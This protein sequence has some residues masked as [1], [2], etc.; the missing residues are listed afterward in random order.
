MRQ[1]VSRPSSRKRSVRRAVEQAVAA[2]RDE[3]L[4]HDV[5]LEPQV[6][7][8]ARDVGRADLDDALGSRAAVAR[9]LAAEL[10]RVGVGRVHG[11]AQA[12]RY[13]R[14]TGG[15][16]AER[17]RVVSPVD[18]RMVAERALADDAEIARCSSAPARRRRAGRRSRCARAR[19]VSA[20]VDAAEARAAEIAE[21]LTLADGAPDRAQPGRG[22][23]AR[24]ARARDDGARR[25]GAG[26]PRARRRS[27]ISP[28]SCAAS[29]SASCW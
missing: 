12:G 14:A 15:G 4:S 22:A 25:G 5:F 18:G 27:P 26:R 10:E 19:R 16:D 9:A 17:I 1:R 13:R 28:A 24:R 29:R 21:E 23:R 7:R 3:A 2:P 20:F 6:L 8:D 11:A